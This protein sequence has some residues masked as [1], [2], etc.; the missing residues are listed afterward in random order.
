M[1]RV[2]EPTPFGTVFL[3]SSAVLFSLGYNPSCGEPCGTESADSKAV[4]LF[5]KGLIMFG[6]FLEQ[7]IGS[8][9]DFTDAPAVQM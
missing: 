2:S 1:I 8:L 9:C 6:A 3:E 7:L 4:A 5:Q